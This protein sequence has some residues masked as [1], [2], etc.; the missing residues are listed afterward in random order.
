MI[1][2][3]GYKSI[4]VVV[5]LGLLKDINAIILFIMNN[6]SI[7]MRQFAEKRNLKSGDGKRGRID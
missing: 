4:R 2:H 7:L 1:F 6:I 5:S 3:E